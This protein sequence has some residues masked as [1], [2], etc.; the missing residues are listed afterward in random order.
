MIFHITYIYISQY[1][2]QIAP[3]TESPDLIEYR[4]NAAITTNPQC[5]PCLST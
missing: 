4:F 5:Y 2:R 3:W 1:T